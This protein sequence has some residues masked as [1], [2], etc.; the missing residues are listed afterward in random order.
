MR[1]LVAFLPLA[2]L[3]AL[4]ALFGGWSLWRSSEVVPEAMVGKPLPALTIARLSGGAPAGLRLMAAAPKAG[5]YVLASGTGHT[6]RELAQVAFACVGL[7]AALYLRVDPQLVRPPETSR[8]LGDWSRARD[9]LGW[10]PQIP[11]EEL[12]AEMVAADLAAL[13]GA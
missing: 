3:L 4:V 11:F 1:R 2:A 8:P 5:D 12:I 6:V 9:L 7:D 13:T 10:A